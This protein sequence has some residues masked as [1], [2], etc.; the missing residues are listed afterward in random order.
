MAIASIFHRLSGLALFVLMPVML[1]WLS[2]S[3]RS[4]TSFSELQTMLMNPYYKALLWIFSTALTY[5]V[6]AGFR[7]MM[8][9]L[10]LG[11]SAAMGR[12]SA[13]GVIALAACGAILMGVWI[14]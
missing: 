9:D 14:W 10:G 11:E 8:M 1:Y 3:L 4:E 5:H 13:I 6:L 12:L 2:L 7:H